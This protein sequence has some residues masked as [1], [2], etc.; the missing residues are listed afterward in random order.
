MSCS[1]LSFVSFIGPIFFDIA[2]DF[3]CFLWVDTRYDLLFKFGFSEKELFAD[4]LNKALM[5]FLRELN[6]VSNILQ[7]RFF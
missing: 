1:E 3:V 7:F 4:L 5:L 6:D 2:K